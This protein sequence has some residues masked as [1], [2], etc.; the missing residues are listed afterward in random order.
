VAALLPDQSFVGPPGLIPGV[1]FRR[2][3]PADN[4]VLYGIGFGATTPVQ[5][6]GQ[7]VAEAASL[8]GVA[9]KIGNTAAK[10]QFAG[11]AAG[12]VGLYQFNIVIPSGESGDVP[13][14]VT[15]GAQSST[16]KVWI[17][18]Q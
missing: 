10:V 15:L 2:A 5:P 14:T 9:V 17:A 1:A 12:L 3:A 7:I 4:L 13:F 8:A 16:Q 11:L 18:L 6:S